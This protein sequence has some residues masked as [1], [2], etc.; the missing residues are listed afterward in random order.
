M[1]EPIPFTPADS[2]KVVTKLV[3]LYRAA[4]AELLERMA[5]S[6]A[7]GVDAPD[8][9][10]RQLMEVQRYR[11]AAQQLLASLGGKAVLEAGAA[12]DNAASKGAVTGLADLI[13]QSAPGPDGIVGNPLD[14]DKM[15]KLA[16]DLARVTTQVDAQILR[17]V[18]DIYRRVIADVTR[19][20]LLGTMTRRD[21]AERALT[22]FARAG[23]TGFIDKAGKRWE[24][25]SYVEM[26]SRAAVM[27]ASIEG[28]TQQLRDSGHDL[29]IV[30]DVP[31]ECEKCR[32]FEGCV[33]SLGGAVVGAITPDGKKV[34]GSL[35]HARAEGLFHPGCRHSIAVY[36]PG[37][38]R[39]FGETADPEGDKARQRLR[40]LERRVRAAR[41]EELAALTPEGK[42]QAAAKV[43][44]L[45]AQIR[46]HVKTTSAKRQPHRERLNTAR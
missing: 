5:E 38:T 19:S 2:A 30:S 44:A 33:L 25:T 32:R 35:A 24:L 1:T 45:Q 28:H 42:K 40:L 21:A 46:E 20:D 11:R 39:S 10:E 14:I 4:E 22:R 9:V 3:E 16:A 7:K 29:I 43:R 34:A 15:T 23:V 41:R 31:Q 36:V 8:W 18:D 26:A 13:R 6:I 17:S 37:V 27:N 12:I